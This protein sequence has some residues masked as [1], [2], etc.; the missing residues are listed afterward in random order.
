MQS[1]KTIVDFGLKSYPNKSLNVL[2]WFLD[3]TKTVMMPSVWMLDTSRFEAVYKDIPRSTLAEIRDKLIKAAVTHGKD[4]AL[5]INKALANFTS[6]NAK[7]DAPEAIIDRFAE[8]VRNGLSYV[9]R[10]EMNAAYRSFLLEKFEEIRVQKIVFTPNSVVGT[11]NDVEQAW[12]WLQS[13]GTTIEVIEQLATIKHECLNLLNYMNT[14]YDMSG[15]M[16]PV[17]AGHCFNLWFG[18]VTPASDTHLTDMFSIKW[19]NNAYFKFKEVG[20]TLD[21]LVKDFLLLDLAIRHRTDSIFEADGVP[22]GWLHEIGIVHYMPTTVAGASFSEYTKA[23]FTRVLFE[24]SMMSSADPAILGSYLNAAKDYMRMDPTNQKPLDRAARSLMTY[25][26]ACIDTRAILRDLINQFWKLLS[27]DGDIDGYYPITIGAPYDKKF[28]LLKRT[29]KW[30]DH[31]ESLEQKLFVA[32]N[33]PLNVKL[34][35]V[36]HLATY[37]YTN[38]FSKDVSLKLQDLFPNK[39]YDL[40]NFYP[41]KEFDKYWRICTSVKDFNKDIL[42]YTEWPGPAAKPFVQHANFKRYA[43]FTP[44]GTLY[45]NGYWKLFMMNQL[46]NTEYSY[47]LVEAG[48]AKSQWFFDVAELSRDLMLPTAVVEKYA[49]DQ[50]WTFPNVYLIPDQ[51]LIICDYTES[52]ADRRLFSEQEFMFGNY[53]GCPSDMLFTVERDYKVS[54]FKTVLGIDSIKE[55]ARKTTDP[56]KDAGLER[57]PDPE[58]T[59]K[60]EQVLTPDKVLEEDPA[61]E[62]VKKDETK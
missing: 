53:N 42:D 30:Y 26:Q 15:P 41:T 35:Q 16:I 54:G 29:I 27:N 21:D 50:K 10:P 60:V 32:E 11:F 61:K 43:Y 12:L 59:E 1:T 13:S 24:H 31:L 51:H 47:A 62:E 55:L 48:Q 36:R 44:L 8:S 7:P 28:Q 18:M 19:E 58:K 6:K 25:A 39:F 4:N 40:S 38:P 45:A 56:V 23:I 34:K 49:K 33:A 2:D 5:D 22:S 9:I 17:P 37:T 52:V 3:Q 14:Y 20:T 46:K 57:H